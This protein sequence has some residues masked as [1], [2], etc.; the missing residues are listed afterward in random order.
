M[1]LIKFSRSDFYVRLHAFVCCY[2]PIVKFIGAVVSGTP[3]TIGNSVAD[4]VQAGSCPAASTPAAPK[5]AIEVN[6]SGTL[7]SDV[8]PTLVNI[9][10]ANSADNWEEPYPEE[11]DIAFLVPGMLTTVTVLMHLSVTAMNK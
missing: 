5:A 6:V 7:L 10:F 9:P 2:W 1:P 8:W 3:S 11:K 4:G